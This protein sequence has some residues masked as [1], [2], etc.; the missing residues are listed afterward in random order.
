MV[1]LWKLLC[2][3]QQE[4]GYKPNAN[5]S[6]SPVARPKKGFQ[7]AE[8]RAVA[9][10]IIAQGEEPKAYSGT[11]E[12]MIAR[13]MLLIKITNVPSTNAKPAIAVRGIYFPICG[14]IREKRIAAIKSIIR[15][16]ERTGF[17]AA[18]VGETKASTGAPP[19][20]EESIL[21]MELYTPI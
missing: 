9:A 10:T 4:D 1:N 2:I 17:G 20:K 18:A 16:L 8:I 5:L 6:T 21:A 19:K 12:E 3:E 7:R 14:T 13:C 15:T 11:G